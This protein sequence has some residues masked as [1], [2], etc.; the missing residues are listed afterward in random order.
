MYASDSSAPTFSNMVNGQINLRD[1]I[2]RQIDFEVGGKSYKLSKTP[3]VLI[4]RYV[5]LLSC[6]RLCLTLG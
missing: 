6:E 3:A 1:A 4:V 5:F 2:N